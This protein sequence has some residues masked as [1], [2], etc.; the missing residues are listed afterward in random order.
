MHIVSADFG[1]FVSLHPPTHKTTAV[2]IMDECME[3]LYEAHASAMG[4]ASEGSALQSMCRR[5]GLQPVGAPLNIILS[6][7][8]DAVVPF[9]Y[10]ISCNKTKKPPAR[11]NPDRGFQIG[12]RI[13]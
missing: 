11:Y 2:E 4:D 1:S 13:S 9:A 10:H 8:P 12:V 3:G 7:N 5:D 6:D